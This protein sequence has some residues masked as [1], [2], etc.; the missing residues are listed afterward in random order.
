MEVTLIQNPKF[1][2]DFNQ[3]RRVETE[4]RELSA[5]Q[6]ISDIAQGII[7][8]VG[9]VLISVRNG[10]FLTLKHAYSS[11]SRLILDTLKITDFY[12]GA[13]KIAYWVFTLG[14]TFISSNTLFRA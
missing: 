14:F 6:L 5:T 4:Q 10:A 13:F 8:F 11:F 2:V 9:V 1:K 3:F 7:R 12:L